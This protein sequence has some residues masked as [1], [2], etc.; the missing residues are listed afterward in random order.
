VECEARRPEPPHRGGRGG[1]LRTDQMLSLDRPMASGSEPHRVRS[2]GGDHPAR[3]LPIHGPADP[4]GGGLS[5]RSPGPAGRPGGDRHGTAVADPGPTRAR[6]DATR[7]QLISKRVGGEVYVSFPGFFGSPPGLSFRYPGEG[8]GSFAFETPHPDDYGG[9]PPEAG[10][11]PSTMGQTQKG[12]RPG[13]L[14]SQGS[15]GRNIRKSTSITTTF[16]LFAPPS[17]GLASDSPKDSGG[18]HRIES[19]EEAS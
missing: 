7:R 13:D 19:T 14:D 8:G 3:T 15:W 11:S 10:P 16:K 6:S 17:S 18:R 2:R 4:G 9:R 1:P 12:R 5:R